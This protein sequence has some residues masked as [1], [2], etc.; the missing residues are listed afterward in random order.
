MILRENVPL[1]SL[2]T[3]RVGGNAR[4]VVDC[5]SIEDV[6]KGLAFAREHGLAW[7][8]LGEGSNVLAHDGGY[9]GAVLLM[10]IP[11]IV[12]TERGNEVLLT[13][14]AGVNWDTLVRDAATRGLWGLENL[15][16]IP[17]TV[18]AAPVQNIGAYGAEVKDTLFEVHAIDAE[19]GE[20]CVFGNDACDFGY[21]DSRFKKQR[22]LIIVTVSFLLTKDAAPRLEYKDLATAVAEGVEHTTPGA[23]GTMVRAIRACKF[24]DLAVVGTAGSFFKNPTVSATSFSVLKERHADLPG[25][26]N[27]QGVKIPLAFVLDRVLNLRG[28]TEGNVSLFVHQPLVLV[29]TEGATAKEIDVF[30]DQIAARV[31][32]EIGVRI[33]R[34]VQPFPIENN[35]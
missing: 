11:D 16:G 33:E 23:I 25:F 31:Y 13:A 22:N 1:A 18:G 17:G 34:E 26:P 30:A 7:S 29:A 32:E 15:A 5:E 24:P 28:Y 2:T 8:V 20:A 3:L 6:G 14:G 9:E 12:V 27:N 21:R 10:Q 4:F 35:F 19:T